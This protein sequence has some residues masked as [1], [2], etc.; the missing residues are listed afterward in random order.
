MYI[1]VIKIGDT[2]CKTATC[3]WIYYSLVALGKKLFLFMR[4]AEI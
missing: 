4:A 2:L 3:E 1:S